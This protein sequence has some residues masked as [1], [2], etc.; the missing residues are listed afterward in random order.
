MERWGHTARERAV[1][2]HFF[3][4]GSR[5]EDRQKGA[6]MLYYVIKW[7]DGKADRYPTTLYNQLEVLNI[8]REVKHATNGAL[9]GKIEIEED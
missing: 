1:L 3:I 6:S 9:T 7:N 2:H 8:I 5:A 4:L